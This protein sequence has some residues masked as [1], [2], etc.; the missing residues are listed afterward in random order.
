MV[1]L[2]LKLFRQRYAGSPLQRGLGDFSS[3]NLM[4]GEARQSQYSFVI[5]TL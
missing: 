3:K 2:H 5:L 1:S 4:V